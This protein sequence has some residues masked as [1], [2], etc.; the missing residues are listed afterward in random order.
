M[1]FCQH[2]YNPTKLQNLHLILIVTFLAHIAITCRPFVINFTFKS[3]QNPLN[4]IKP[5][6]S[7]VIC[8]CTTT[9]LFIQDGSYY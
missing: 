3:S 5:N 2:F 7:E 6:F 4:Q 8:L 9:L 1:Y